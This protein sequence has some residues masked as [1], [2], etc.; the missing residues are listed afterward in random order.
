MKRLTALV[1]S[2]AMALS[3]AACGGSSST[4]ETDSDEILIYTFIAARDEWNTTLEQGTLNCGIEGVKVVSQNAENDA[5]KQLQQIETA[6]TAGAQALIVQMADAETLAEIEEAAQGVPVVMV[7]R[8]PSDYSLLNE[9]VIYLG[10]DEATA[11][12][13]QGDY[14]TEYFKAQG[15]TDFTYLLLSGALGTVPARV[16]TDSVLSQLEANGM[17]ATEATSPLVCDWDRATAMDNVT[18]LLGVTEFDCIISNNDAMALG[19]IEAL[20][21]AGMDPSSIPIVGVDATGD[22]R[23]A[24]AE[25]KMAM[26]AFQDGDEMGKAAVQAALN[27]INGKEP[28]EGID[29]KPTEDNP[30]VLAKDFVMVTADNVDEIG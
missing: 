24:V 13:Q 29:Y 22:G 15:K 26:T 6:V 27:M 30:Y 11:G 25:G 18:P 12:Y 1:L 2:L 21:Q 17:N 8:N 7:N 28:S 10:C 23:A 4:S 14:L 5:I 19:A 3:L 16:R 20:E 9:N